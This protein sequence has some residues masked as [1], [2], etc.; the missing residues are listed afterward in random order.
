MRQMA[1]RNT[2]NMS[3]FCRERQNKAYNETSEGSADNQEVEEH[4]SDYE[5]ANEDVKLDTLREQYDSDDESEALGGNSR[6]AGRP[7]TTISGKNKFKWSK[8]A[9]ESRGRRSQTTYTPAGIG[10][11]QDISTPI[12]A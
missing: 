7:R 4:A 10:L 11:A 5:D 2:K 6:R 12:E 1:S 3:Y 8:L 9:P